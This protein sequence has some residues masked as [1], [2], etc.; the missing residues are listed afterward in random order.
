MGLHGNKNEATNDSP[1]H[2][3]CNSHPSDV[4]ASPP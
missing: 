2:N 1:I 4:R 3:S